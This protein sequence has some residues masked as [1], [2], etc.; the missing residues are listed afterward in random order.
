MLSLL[1]K[2]SDQSSGPVI[3]AWHPNFRNQEKLPD[4][5]V[6]RTAF[7]VNGA[8]IVIVASLAIYL[9]IHES[10]L[11]SLRTQLADVNKQIAHDKAPSDHAVAAYK[12][13]QAEEAK[14]NEVAAFVNSKPHVSETLLRL[15]TTLP[16][17]VAL[18]VFDLRETG[19]NLKLTVRGTPEEAAG[20]ATAY[21]EQLRADEALTAFDHT[22]FEFTSQSRD[23]SSGRLAVEF[24]LRLKTPGGK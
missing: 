11:R 10:Q 12:S 7:F 13:F 14:V 3:P 8:A 20:Y 24:F 23:P 9:G 19:L 5:K 16:E 21:F 17:N 6:V 4:V 18:D 2:K 22:K 1:K 15:A